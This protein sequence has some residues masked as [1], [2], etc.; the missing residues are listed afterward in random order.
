MFLIGKGCDLDLADTNEL[1]A[2]HAAAQQ[3]HA[4]AALLLLACGACPTLRTLSG[5]T[6]LDLVDAKDHTTRSA[7]ALFHEAQKSSHPG[8]SPL[9]LAVR[10]RQ[11]PA[12][13]VLCQLED[14]DHLDDRGVTALHL[15]IASGQKEIAL[16]LLK[17]G[18]DPD[19]EDAEG[20]SARRMA[21][22]LRYT[23]QDLLKILDTE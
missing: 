21:R 1:T 15:A 8:E 7:F 9:H 10:M 18:A 22:R 13:L 17:A 23:D 20:T 6:P 3:G 19:K 12:V 5:R 4:Q 2:L 11:L 16:A 14:V